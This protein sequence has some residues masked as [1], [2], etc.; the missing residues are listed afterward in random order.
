MNHCFKSEKQRNTKLNYCLSTKLYF[1][2]NVLH[3]FQNFCKTEQALTFPSISQSPYINSTCDQRISMH[4]SDKCRVV[5]RWF[6]LFLFHFEFV[7]I[8]LFPYRSN[9]LHC[10]D[11]LSIAF[12]IFD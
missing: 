2:I 6:Q 10:N 11:W 9:E 8:A 1:I 5:S 3:F 4:A 7:E 12:Q